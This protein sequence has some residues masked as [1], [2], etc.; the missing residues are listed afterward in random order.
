[1][2]Q[3]GWRANGARKDGLSKKS[4]GKSKAKGLAGEIQHFLKA[5]PSN[6]SCSQQHFQG[7]KAQEGVD[8]RRLSQPRNVHPVSPQPLFAAAPGAVT[9]DTSEPH[10]PGISEPNPHPEVQQD[11]RSPA[12]AVPAPVLPP[13]AKPSALWMDFTHSSIS[14][15][16]LAMS[17]HESCPARLCSPATPAKTHQ[18]QKRHILVVLFVK[19]F[20]KPRWLQ[21][22]RSFGISHTEICKEGTE[23]A[24]AA[25]WQGCSSPWAL[26]S[27]GLCFWRQEFHFP[28]QEGGAQGQGR[29]IPRG[30]GCPAQKC[31][32]RSEASSPG[33]ISKMNF[34]PSSGLVATTLMV[35]PWRD[36]QP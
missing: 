36:R 25:A 32:R 4:Q 20:S 18:E 33:T 19:H 12:G 21:G 34:P 26:P 15:C 8:K 6:G 28:W 30:L 22:K 7:Q 9:R 23:T 10:F 16:E 35:L 2:T 27:P 24:A 14:A 1:M 11:R 5:L 17:T 29:D 3:A 13:G 31:A